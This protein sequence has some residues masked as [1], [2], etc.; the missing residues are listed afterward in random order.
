METGLLVEKTDTDANQRME[1]ESTNKYYDRFRD[2]I[3]FPIADPMGKIIGF[4]ARVAPGGDES[5]AK[6]INT[7]ETMAYHKSKV[8]YGI[9]KAKQEIKNQDF[10]L[11]VEGNTDVIAAHQAGLKNTV[12]VSGTALTA[13]QLDILKR[14]S[15]NIKML[16]DMDEAGEQATLKSAQVAFQKEFNVYVTELSEGKD[17]AEVAVKDSSKLSQAVEKSLPAMEYFF[18]QIFEKYDKTKAQDKKVIAKELL[19]IMSNLDNEIEKT[20]WIKKLAQGLE[21][22]EKVL[23]NILNKDKRAERRSVSKEDEQEK[24]APQKRSEIIRERVVGLMLAD[25]DVW[26][27]MIGQDQSNTTAF[28]KEDELFNM[29]TDKGEQVE[30]NYDNILPEIESKEMSDRARKLYFD[31]KYHFD[32]QQGIKENAEEDN[33]PLTEQYIGEIKKEICK[34]RLETISKDLKKAEESGD[35][36]AVNFLMKEFSE[37]SRELN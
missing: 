5:Q 4:S 28:L 36:E 3:I 8:L 24:I 19:N 6:Y 13:D 31:T 1:S 33:W 11:L 17:A 7:P 23:L 16:F 20:H 37:I 26:K 2:R 34:K 29:L 12:A 14:Y 25:S 9:D 22:E 30:F 35:K 10:T 32:I 15:E 27:K 21:V 18:N